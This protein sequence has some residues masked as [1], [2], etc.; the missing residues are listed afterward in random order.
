MSWTLLPALAWL[1]ALLVMMIAT[2]ALRAPTARATAAAASSMP[3]PQVLLV[4]WHST[5]CAL[6]GATQAGTDGSRP[7]LGKLRAVACKIERISTGLSVGLAASISATVPETMGAEKLV[8][9]D[10]LALSL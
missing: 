6:S 1:A 7:T 2:G 3:A 5:C 8:P 9:S 10:G 4:Q